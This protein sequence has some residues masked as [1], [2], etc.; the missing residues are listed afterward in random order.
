[1]AR[2]T[3]KGQQAFAADG[4]DEGRELLGDGVVKALFRPL[5]LIHLALPARRRAKAS[6]RVRVGE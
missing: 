5:T 2:R 1:M 3:N 4:V 6:V